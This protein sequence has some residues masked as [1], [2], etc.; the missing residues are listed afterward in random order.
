MPQVFGV[1]HAAMLTEFESSLLAVDPRIPGL[2]YLDW[3]TFATN[4]SSYAC[5]MSARAW[6]R[7]ITSLCTRARLCLLR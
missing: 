5:D 3:E 6:H 1:Y 7:D 4:S 2:P